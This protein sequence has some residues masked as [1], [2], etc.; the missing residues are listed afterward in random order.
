[1]R[2]FSSQFNQWQTRSFGQKKSKKVTISVI[3]IVSFLMVAAFVSIVV[4][5]IPS[6]L[7]SPLDNV[8][9]YG[10]KLIS[11]TAI[12]KYL[13]I[14]EGQSWLSIDPYVM[15]IRLKDHPWIKEAIVRRN[16][17]L[18]LDVTI[19]YLKINDQLFM[20]CSDYLVLDPIRGSEQWN[21]PVI[22]N[23]TLT[24][25]LAPDLLA[26]KDLN[27]AFQL[28]E[29]LR[30]NEI[31]PLKAVSEI[32][33]D[34]PLN[35]ELITIPNG[36]KIKMGFQNFKKKL[37]NLALTSRKISEERKRIAAID[38]RYPNGIVLQ[39]KYYKSLE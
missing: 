18:S 2:D 15:S 19:T 1:M 16:L 33:V 34:D 31:L 26:P 27:G 9:I 28:M 23:N 6:Y 14:Y 35:I 30:K 25:V 20:I 10:N 3:G 32:I 4:F 13:R 11:K 37:R 7:S 22:V 29:L 21:L 12:A 36:I 5:Q 38:L 8:R 39:Y 17:R 24:T